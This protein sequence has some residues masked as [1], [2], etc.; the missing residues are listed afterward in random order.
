V[1][2][3]IRE[4][5]KEDIL[6]VRDILKAKDKGIIKVGIVKDKGIVSILKAKHVNLFCR[7][8]KRG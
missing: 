8:H 2:D 7:L 1:A 3:I 4:T 6:R 5:T